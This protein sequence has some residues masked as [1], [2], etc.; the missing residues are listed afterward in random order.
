M[1]NLD[2]EY[3]VDLPLHDVEHLLTVKVQA[4][5]LSFKYE[6][7]D[8]GKIWR[9]N[10]TAKYIEDITQKTGN[11]KKFSVFIK[12]LH[13]A[14][15]DESNSVYM[16]VLTAQDLE[17][18]KRKKL[19]A[20]ASAATTTSTK[21]Y[22]ILTSTNEFDKVHYPL[23]LSYEDNPDPETLRQT[24]TRLSSAIESYRSKTLSMT[25]PANI[26]EV[27][28]TSFYSE[29]SMSSNGF[30]ATS[31]TVEEVKN[32]NEKLRRKLAL[33]E[34]TNSLQDE[35]T[36]NKLEHYKSVD[37]YLESSR[38]EMRTLNEKLS[39]TE[40]KL[41]ETQSELLKTKSEL[42]HYEQLQELPPPELMRVEIERLKEELETEQKNNKEVISKQT[43]VLDANMKELEKAKENDKVIRAKIHELEMKIEAAVKKNTYSMYGN[44]YSNRSNSNISNHSNSSYNRYSPSQTRAQANKRSTSLPQRKPVNTRASPAN[45]YN[46]RVPLAN[47]KYQPRYSPIPNRSN[48]GSKPNY[49]RPTYNSGGGL[50]TGYHNGRT[51]AAT[52]GS[53]QSP[54]TGKKTSGTNLYGAA[55]K[56]PVTNTY[57]RRSPGTY[58]AARRNPANN[59]PSPLRVANQ[60]RP[61]V[62]PANDS[63]KR[64][65]PG[66]FDRL[67]NP[68]GSKRVE[69]RKEEQKGKLD[70]ANRMIKGSSNIDDRLRNLQNIIKAAK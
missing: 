55:R 69:G 39:E 54:A 30:N 12:M 63:W 48:S 66:V 20:P 51:N 34:R 60:A 56:S 36:F 4:N 68:T 8:T 13:S 17:E 37:R 45:T 46:K 47:S 50:K 23:P 24:I 65:S 14:L 15:K 38:L 6:E 52:Q 27:A 21:R 18:L 22:L 32:E 2:Q 1:E 58:G 9:G 28:K 40:R 16:D 57:A 5:N 61:A 26:S 62:P 11:F 49:M 19:G 33:L 25:S 70:N 35:D 64:S 59:G 10:F 42:G 67:Y 7:K 29:A 41:R 31:R 44:R 53:R 3:T 43:E